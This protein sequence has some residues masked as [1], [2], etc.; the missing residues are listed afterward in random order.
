MFI[1]MTA[2]DLIRKP[3]FNHQTTYYVVTVAVSLL[4]WPIAAA[5]QAVAFA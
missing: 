1:A 5:F 3:H 2:Q 4:I